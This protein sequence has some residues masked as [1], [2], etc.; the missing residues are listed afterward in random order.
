[1]ICLNNNVRSLFNKKKCIFLF[2]ILKELASVV[3]SGND[4][5]I[6]YS[7][8]FTLSGSMPITGETPL[9]ISQKV[10]IMIFKHLEFHF[11]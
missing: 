1:M 7:K 11:T 3:R 4:K 5:Y 6:R 10:K 2:N 9:E 8:W